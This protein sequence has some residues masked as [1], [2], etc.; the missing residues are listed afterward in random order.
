MMPRY[1]SVEELQ[2]VAQDP[3]AEASAAVRAG[4]VLNALTDWPTA[5][6]EVDELVAALQREIGAPSPTPH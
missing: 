6:Q 4:F 1:L 2:R 5:L 3:V